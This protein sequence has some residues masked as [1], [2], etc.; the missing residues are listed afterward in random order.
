MPGDDPDRPD[1]HLLPSVGWLAVVV[2]ICTLIATIAKGGLAQL[3]AVSAALVSGAVAFAAY[4]QGAGWKRTSYAIASVV[5]LALAV[6]ITAIST[7]AVDSP[8]PSPQTTSPLPASHSPDPT[9]TTSTTTTKSNA[10][11]L[12]PRPSVETEI[13][14]SSSA[15]FFDGALIIGGELAYGS[16]AVLNLTTHQ[17]GCPRV[18]FSVGEEKII[19][20]KRGDGDDFYR[21]T[22]LKVADNSSTVRVEEVPA[23]EWPAPVTR[24]DESTYYNAYCPG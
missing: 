21:I 13:V 23:T 3:L 1:L 18:S 20:G 12:P 15:E 16:T 14:S 17:I 11:A 7:I 6:A 22:L 2:A 24:A 10:S 4:R 9:T 8:A 5:S 19:I